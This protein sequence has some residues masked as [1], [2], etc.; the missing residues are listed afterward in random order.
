VDRINDALAPA[1][2][3]TESFHI[4]ERL[5]PSRPAN[6][7]DKAFWLAEKQ[8]NLQRHASYILDNLEQ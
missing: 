5:I 1:P 3:Q 2:D 4:G 8:Y 7:F 6:P